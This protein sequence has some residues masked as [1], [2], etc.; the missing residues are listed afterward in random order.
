NPL[1]VLAQ[2]IV[3]MTSV[4][5]WDIDTLYHFV[6]T[7]Y[8]FRHLPRRHFDAVVGM[9]AGKYEHARVRALDP[10]ISIDGLDN[11]ARAAGPARN[12]LYTSG[13]TIPDRGYY[14]LR[15]AESRAK[16]G[17]LDEEFV[18]ERRL[19]ESFTLGTQSWKIQQITH[20]DV[21]VTPV[22]SRPLMVPFWRAE[23]MLRPT[24]A[25]LRLG[26]FLEEADRRIEDP[27]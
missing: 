24:H 25:S 8:T 3:S 26:G 19:G 22:K 9:L 12:R 20:N 5:T 2:M 7:C 23:D 21:L 17:E 10:V 6:L 1:D 18:W 4:E 16:I 11:T 13:G 14:N 15:V 27:G